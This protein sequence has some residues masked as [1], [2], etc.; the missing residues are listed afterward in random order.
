MHRMTLHESRVEFMDE[1]FNFMDYGEVKELSF[2]NFDPLVEEIPSA[3]HLEDFSIQFQLSAK[4][5]HQKRIV[6]DV[7]TMFGDVG[8]L[9]DF[10]VI[11]LSST[12]GLFSESFMLTSLVANLFLQPAKQN[13]QPRRNN[14]ASKNFLLEPIQFSKIFT[15]LRALSC[16]LLPCK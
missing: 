7:F 13:Q 4:V 9:N 11:A 5:M 14:R 10:L 6:Y 2:L 3:D 12:L 16:G 1:R 15:V 8:G